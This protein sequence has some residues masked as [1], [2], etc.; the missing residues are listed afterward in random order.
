[1]AL[2]DFDKNMA[3]V[4]AEAPAL[5]TNA[6]T[7]I[8]SAIIDCANLQGCTF[9]GILGTLTD[10]NVTYA[11]TME[12]GDDSGLSDTAAAA[13]V[14]KDIT[15][16][17]PSGTFADDLST[18]QIGYIGPKRYCRL[19]LTPTGNNSGDLPF[20]LVVITNALRHYS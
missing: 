17:L 15:R 8:I 10:V 12:Q 2:R 1:M 18:F 9:V 6:D 20:A 5:N 3:A 16:T 4:F 13:T 19:T 14:G 11:V 7:A